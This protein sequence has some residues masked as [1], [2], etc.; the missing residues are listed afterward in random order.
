MPPVRPGADHVFHLF[1]VNCQQR[2]DLRQR[3][4]VAGISTGIH[5][6]RPVYAHPAFACFGGQRSLPATEFQCETTLSLPMHPY[7]DDADVVYIADTVVS[8]AADL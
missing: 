5:Y 7:L 2:D 8:C 6:S 4:S 3:L 1:T